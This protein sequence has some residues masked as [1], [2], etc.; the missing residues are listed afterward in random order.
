[1]SDSDDSD[2]HS[3][4]STGHAETFLKG[5]TLRGLVCGLAVLGGIGVASLGWAGDSSEAGQVPPGSFLL[6]VS[7]IL[8]LVSGIVSGTE[9]AIFSLDRFEVLRTKSERSASARALTRLLES[10][11]DALTTLLILNNLVNVGLSLAAGALAESYFGGSG[12]AALGV[13]G[14]AVTALIVTFGEVLPKCVAQ[15]HA[16]RWA[17]VMAWPIVACATLLTP[18]RI[19]MNAFISSVFERLDVP[20]ATGDEIVSEEELKAMMS[21]GHASTLLEEDERD[22][23]LGVFQLDNTFAEEIM[24]PRSE[25]EAVEAS[26]SQKEVLERL[27]TT[28]HSRILVYEDDL[29]QLLG[30]VLAKEVLLEPERR[31][32]ER[33]REIVCIPCRLRL[34]ELLTQFRRQSAKI[35][36]VVDEYGQVSGIVTLH[37]LLEEIVGEITERHEK[38]DPEI[39]RFG[40]NSFA[41][42]GRAKLSDL[43]RELGID[44]P[45]DLASTAG[46]FVMNT[47]GKVPSVG[48]ELSYGGYDFRVKR[49]MGR[50]IIELEASRAPKG[51]VGETLEDQ[52]EPGS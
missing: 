21:G 4:G 20:E 46:G 48:S 17:S 29:D 13:A 16:R 27:R 22:M 31:W 6:W 3:L 30:F 34:D 51:A 38:A 44:F 50:R 11:N 33:V 24:I 5:L 39:R 42:L 40:E 18:F 2:P 28:H 8:L 41:V 37:D 32:Q 12:A 47:L 52:G 9:T 45:N 35:A 26:L 19:V 49:M 14:F 43:G 36:A 1:M 15:V 7:S 23:I 10:P 25:V